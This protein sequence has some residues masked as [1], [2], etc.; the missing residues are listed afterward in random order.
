MK[1]NVTSTTS[2]NKELTHRCDFREHFFF[3]FII[4]IH[5][6]TIFYL[7]QCSQTFTNV[8]PNLQKFL[9]T[10]IYFIIIELSIN[11]VN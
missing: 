9:L 6:R 4:F 11:S 2:F 10:V 3:N 1:H 5:Q 7:E 8:Q